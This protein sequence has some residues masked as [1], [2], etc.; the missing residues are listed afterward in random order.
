MNVQTVQWMLLSAAIAATAIGVVVAHQYWDE[1]IV[2][3]VV[4]VFAVLGCFI[5]LAAIVQNTVMIVDSR[6]R[7]RPP[8]PHRRR[9]L[10]TK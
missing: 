7:N 6:D 9:K 1:K 2:K 4:T 3:I 8:F 10:A 5:F